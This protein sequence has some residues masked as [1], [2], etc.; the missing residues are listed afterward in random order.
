[1]NFPKFSMLAELVNSLSYNLLTI[2]ISL[3]FT[4]KVLGYYS[5][6]FKILSLPAS[7]I[8]NSISQV[9]YQ[10]ASNELRRDNKITNSFN[11]V[12][13]K[14]LISVPIFSL[15]YFIIEDLFTI[16]FGLNW[17]LAG[18]YAK[19]L[20]PLFLVRFISSALSNTLSVLEKQKQSLVINTLLLISSISIIL[21]SNY[22]KYSFIHFLEIFT[23]V[24]SLEYLLFLFYYFLLSRRNY[25]KFH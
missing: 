20:I 17:Q 16:V 10:E 14:L 2:L 18:I 22:L 23:F 11:H 1:M 19:I 13:L 7:L 3:F 25:E 9:Y 15:I 8:G 12:F 6:V 5:L 21:L 4:T 24:M